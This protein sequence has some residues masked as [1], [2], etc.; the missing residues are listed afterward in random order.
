MYAGGLSDYLWLMDPQIENVQIGSDKVRFEG[1]HSMRNFL[2][3][4]LTVSEY[5]F[6]SMANF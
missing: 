3:Y 6:Y 1:A 5:S 4:I 2:K